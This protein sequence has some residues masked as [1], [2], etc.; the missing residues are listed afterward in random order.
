MKRTALALTTAGLASGLLLAGTVPADATIKALGIAGVRTNMAKGEVRAVKGEPRDIGYG[1]VSMV[2]KVTRWK[3][4]R[5]GD[6]LTVTFA[7]GVVIQVAT[8]SEKQ[9]TKLGV[10]PGSPASLF[11]EKYP[12]QASTCYRVRPGVKNCGYTPD[13]GAHELS[14]QVSGDRVVKVVAVLGTY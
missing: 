12:A 14:F 11:K 8:K 13:P 2:G 10:G 9:R 7:E 3:Y 5:N 6:R 4:G 1:R